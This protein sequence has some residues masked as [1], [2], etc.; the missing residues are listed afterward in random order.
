MIDPVR[1]RNLYRF[2]LFSI[3]LLGAMLIFSA[4]ADDEAQ[5]RALVMRRD[6]EQQRRVTEQAR[7]DE[8][9]ESEPT[10]TWH[11]NN[12]ICVCLVVEGQRNGCRALRTHSSARLVGHRSTGGAR[13]VRTRVC[14]RQRPHSGPLAR[15]CCT[16]TVTIVSTCASDKNSA[17]ISACATSSVRAGV[18]ALIQ[19]RPL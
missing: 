15:A 13:Q 1:Q 19:K 4:Y 17:L 2:T 9:C 5:R 7:L 18:T 8:V 6:R 11:T 14:V 10:G 3:P 12:T 16:N